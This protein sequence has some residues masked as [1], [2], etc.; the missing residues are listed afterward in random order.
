MSP[1][2]RISSFLAVDLVIPLHLQPG[3]VAYTDEIATNA[4]FVKCCKGRDG[5]GRGYKDPEAEV[6]ALFDFPLRL[7]R[8]VPNQSAVAD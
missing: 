7:A 4:L 5:S 6:V 1:G 8:L 2:G 3:N